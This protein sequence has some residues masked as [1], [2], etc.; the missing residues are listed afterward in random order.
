MSNRLDQE[1]EQKLSPVRRDYAIK[2]LFDVGI[3]DIYRDETK[4]Q[5]DFKGSKVTL[6][7]YSG[8]FTGKGIR[9]GRGI[10]MLLKQLK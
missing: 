7:F 1:R 2:Q 4:I 10:D 5:F 8:W 6:Y 9:D 3:I